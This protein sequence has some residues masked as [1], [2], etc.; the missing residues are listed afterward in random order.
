VSNCV[1]LVKGV[2]YGRFIVQWQTSLYG[3]IEG[4]RAIAKECWTRQ[5][6]KEA[7]LPS[8]NTILYSNR[9]SSYAKLR[10]PSMHLIPE[11]YVNVLMTNLISPG[12][13]VDPN[14]DCRD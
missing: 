7:P 3:K 4:K 12:I 5:W 2:N 6:T 11:V 9:V 10:V 1:D 13:V 14:K 8:C